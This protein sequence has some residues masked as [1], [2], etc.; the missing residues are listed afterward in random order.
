[1]ADTDSYS[2]RDH[3]LEAFLNSEVSSSS[4]IKFYTPCD[5]SDEGAEEMN[6][7]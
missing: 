2:G 6:V 7:Y 5:D 3:L 4:V 1:M